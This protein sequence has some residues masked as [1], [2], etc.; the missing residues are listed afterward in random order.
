MMDLRSGQT[1]LLF[2][3]VECFT[4]PKRWGLVKKKPRNCHRTQIKFNHNIQTSIQKVSVGRPGHVKLGNFGTHHLKSRRFKY[5][6]VRNVA[7][8][9]MRGVMSG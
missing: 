4:P 8:V 6:T 2:V 9:D 7:V 1:G 3:V 5:D